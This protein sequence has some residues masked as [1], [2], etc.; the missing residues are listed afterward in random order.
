[1]GLSVEPQNEAV[2]L[3][4]RLVQAPGLSGQEA[5]AA[6]VVEAQMLRLGFD[7]V[8]RDEV[9]NVIGE[10]RGDLP[11]PRLVFEAHMDVVEMSRR[12]DWSVDPF[13]AALRDGRIYGRGAADTKGSLAALITALGSLERAQIRGSLFAVGSVGE[14]T[15]EG[16]GLRHA[17]EALQPQGVVVGEPTGC[18]LAMG[19]K[20]RARIVFWA[21]GRAAHS[22][23]PQLGEN[24]LI[25][26]AEIV[27]RVE[28]LPLLEDAWLGR[29]V[30]APL[31]IQSEPLPPLSSTLPHACQVVYDRRLVLG[32]TQESVLGE[33]R[34]ALADVPGWEL[35]VEEVSFETYTGRVLRAPDFHPGW[36]MPPDSAWVRGA[37]SAL[38]G[39]GIDSRPHAVP[40]CTN[41]STAAGEMG[42]PA[43]IFGPGNIEQ[44]H[45][46]DEY[47]AVED[48]LRGVEGYR[49]LALGLPLALAA[50][51][52]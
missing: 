9:G 38:E 32:E 27:R 51:G 28:S 31:F 34:R 22:S 24:A 43:L 48:L 6:A 50:Q 47:L 4:R 45:V 36:H 40:Y 10:R 26:A 15:L 25:K 14:E 17:L 2:D 44:A 1:M 21:R 11:G 39:A 8:W 42:L 23:T 41:A 37:V 18:R 20:G 49:A 30:M 5:A 35:A 12:E 33:Y 19:Q 29:G 16:A 3:L 7:R 52:A 46:P 13:G